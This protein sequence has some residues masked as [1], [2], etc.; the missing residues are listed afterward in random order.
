MENSKQKNSISSPIKA[1]QTSISAKFKAKSQYDIA[2]IDKMYLKRQKA[3]GYYFLGFS[4][5]IMLNATI[6]F[7]S[8]PFYLPLAN[9]NVIQPTS[10]C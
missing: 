2:Q 6:G 10:E 1:M 9:C 7:S 8:A 4:I 5:F 3:M